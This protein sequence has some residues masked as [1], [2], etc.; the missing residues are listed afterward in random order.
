MTNRQTT[1]VVS[2]RIPRELAERFDE[3]AERA[4][5]PRAGLLHLLIERVVIDETLTLP[6]LQPAELEVRA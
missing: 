3:V 1:R 4:A 2:A 6:A 5:L